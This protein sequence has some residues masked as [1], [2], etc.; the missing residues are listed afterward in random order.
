[1]CVARSNRVFDMRLLRPTP[2]M[3]RP[4]ISVVI[5]CYNYGH[6]LPEAVVSALDQTGVDVDVLIVDDASTDDSATIA[7]GLAAA[8]DRVK[9]TVHQTN[10]GHIETYN[11]GLSAATGDYVV[12]LSA[13]DLLKKDALTR[14]AALFEARPDV[15]LVYGRVRSFTDTPPEIGE[16]RMTW[17]VWGGSEWLGHVCRRGRNI[18]INPEAVMRTDL[19]HEL[20]G[21]DAAHPQTADMLLWMRAAARMR[22]GRV[23]GPLQAGYRTHGANMHRTVFAGPLTDFGNVRAA[24]ASFFEEFPQPRLARKAQHALAREGLLV[25]IEQQAAGDDSSRAAAFALE[26]DPSLRQ[27]SLWRRYERRT[28][29]FTTGEAQLVKRIAG[30]RWCLRWQRWWRFGT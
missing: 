28:R 21:Y 16:C 10:Q 17:T 9:V 20:G 25:A 8:D 22:V 15:G 11:H 30:L 13:D 26:T 14:A 1:M 12:L 24:F 18:V 5:P 7:R 27:S 29:R 2:L 23:N 4:R 19:L 6:F 3:S